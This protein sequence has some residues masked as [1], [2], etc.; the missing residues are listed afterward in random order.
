MPAAKKRIEKSSLKAV[1]EVDACYPAA[2]ASDPADKMIRN[3]SFRGRAHVSD[4][5]SASD[6]INTLSTFKDRGMPGPGCK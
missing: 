4:T 2:Q 5:L 3:G 6:L 1:R